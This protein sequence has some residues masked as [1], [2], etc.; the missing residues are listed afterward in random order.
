MHV[1][2]LLVPNFSRPYFQIAPP[3]QTMQR[4]LGQKRASL[5]SAFIA[6]GV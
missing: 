4:L 2:G 1:A 6:A 5:C 3:I